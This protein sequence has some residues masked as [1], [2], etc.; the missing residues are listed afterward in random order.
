MFFLQRTLFLLPVLGL[1]AAL[2]HRRAALAHLL[3]VLPPPIRRKG[4]G[5]V[6]IGACQPYIRPIHLH[7]QFGPQAAR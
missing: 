5:A 2:L 3:P 4:V 7:I 6:A 1:A